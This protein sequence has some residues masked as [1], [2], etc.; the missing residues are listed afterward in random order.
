[1]NQSSSENPAPADLP[2]VSSVEDILAL[3]DDIALD[4]LAELLQ[5][6]IPAARAPYEYGAGQK[7]I[8]LGE[9]KKIAASDYQRQLAALKQILSKS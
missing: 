8:D 1:M 7:T 2:K 3:P 4:K 9:G 5:P 6:F